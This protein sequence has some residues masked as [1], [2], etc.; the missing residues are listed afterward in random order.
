MARRVRD[1]NLESKE[2][3]YRLKAR[4]KPYYRQIE[5]G[6]HVGYR[7]LRGRAG[8]WTARHYQGEGQYKLE[9]I[10]VADDSSDADGLAILDFWQA[11]AKARQQM[12]VR[13]HAAAGKHLGPYTVGDAYRAYLA[14]LVQEGKATYNPTKTGESFIYPTIGEIDCNKL[15][16]ELLQGW[17][18]DL[19]QMPAR[20]R[21]RKGAEQAYCHHGGDAESV[22]RRQSTAMRHWRSL[23]AALARAFHAG[24]ITSDHAWRRVRA[25]KNV[26]SA[27]VRWLTIAE[28]LRLINAAD[29][30]FRP[31]IQVA[32]AT[33]CRYGELC[34][35]EVRDFNIDS[36][37]VQIRMSKSGKSRHVVLTD[38]GIALLTQLTAGRAGHETLLHK[39]DGSPWQAANQIGRMRE[40]CQRAHITP[41]ANFHALRHTFASLAIMNGAPLVVVAKALGHANTNMVQKH[42]G[43]L[44]NDFINES[45][46]A[47]AP[48][49]GFTSDPKLTVLGR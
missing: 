1:T 28:A 19:A 25:F 4:G 48:R 12:V 18:A 29:A 23:R 3:R 17:L 8:T 45:I 16:T 24:K 44:A 34:R 38:E 33:G 27:R 9:V 49:F 32:L 31:M 47:N 40:T 5:A 46:R 6:L 30:D 20:A 10:G 36:G 43:H 13:A 2:G 37:T 11:Q 22:R 35:L 39:A 42:Y 15:T 7:K 26:D 41:A 14:A 21:T